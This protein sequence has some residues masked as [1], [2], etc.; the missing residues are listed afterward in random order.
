MIKKILAITI[1]ATLVCGCS[2]S[3]R[4]GNLYQD[5]AVETVQFEDIEYQV[6]KSWITESNS[7]GWARNY[8]EDGMMISAQEMDADWFSFEFISDDDAALDGYV[9][10][11]KESMEWFQETERE[12]VELDGLTSYRIKADINYNGYT[13]F[14]TVVT[15]FDQHF[16]SFT[17]LA[18]EESKDEYL[19][20]FESLLYSVSVIE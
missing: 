2:N 8:I 3:N 13:S 4:T 15:I 5:E 9:N 16:Y 17:L 14:D 12:Q 6:P 20:E 1:V 19:D 10:G 18:D 7:S 11:L